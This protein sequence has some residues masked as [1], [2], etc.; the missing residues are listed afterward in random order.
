MPV[1]EFLLLKRFAASG[2][3]EAF[4]EIARQHA[5]LVYGVC[6]RILEDRDTAAD[7]VQDT[8]FQLARNADTIT[9]S[10]PNWL[11][12]VAKNR[13]IKLVHQNSSR[14]HREKIYAADSEIESYEETVSWYEIS[15]CIDE[16]LDQLDDLT[17]EVIILHFFEG[18]TMTDIAEK[19]GIS[20]PTVSR[21]IES[22]INTLRQKLKSRGIIVSAAILTSLLIE[23]IIQAAPASIMKE[24]G[25]IALSGGKIATGVKVAAGLSAIKTKII[26]V[27]IVTII[28]GTAVW[29]YNLNGSENSPDIQQDNAQFNSGLFI[30][31]NSLNA[32]QA[33]IVVTDQ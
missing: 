14:K 22:G 15:G 17:R 30:D 5:P 20:Q 24:L 12:R 9:G 3:T 19:F 18:Q 26:A 10:F 25:K 23:N 32:N 7:V 1:S 31:Q 21:R 16:E 27:A 4:A 28:T 8:F 6:L 29:Y 33:T 2:D 11:H 13:A